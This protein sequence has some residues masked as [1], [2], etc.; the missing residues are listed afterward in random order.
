MKCILW[1]WLCESDSVF[2]GCFNCRNGGDDDDDD[3]DEL[4][5]SKQ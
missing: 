4:Y 1:L 5:V 2:P 3:D